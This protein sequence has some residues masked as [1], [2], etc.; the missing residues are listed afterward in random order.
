MSQNIFISS[1]SRPECDHDTCVAP[2][3]CTCRPGL[4]VGAAPCPV[5]RALGAQLWLHVSLSRRRHV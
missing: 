5:P 2:G 3:T 1:V 4:G